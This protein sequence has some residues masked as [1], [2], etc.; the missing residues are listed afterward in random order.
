LEADVSLGRC[1]GKILV[2]MV[3]EVGARFGVPMRPEEIEALMRLSE[4]KQTHVVRSESGDGPD[5]QGIVG[6]G[7]CD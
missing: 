6:G 3:L 4:P 5:E 7:A 1:L 2:Y